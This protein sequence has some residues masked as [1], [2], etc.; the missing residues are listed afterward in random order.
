MLVSLPMRFSRLESYWAIVII[1]SL[2]CLSILL[3][4]MKGILRREALFDIREFI[5]VYCDV[6]LSSSF[7]SFLASSWKLERMFS[8]YEATSFLMF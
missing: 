5:W 6:R 8:K 3:G 2:A 4:F 1:S 7:S